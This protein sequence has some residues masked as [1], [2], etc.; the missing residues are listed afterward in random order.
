[1]PYFAFV[2]ASTVVAKRT[3]EGLALF[4][5]L[6]YTKLVWSLSHNTST[7]PRRVLFFHTNSVKRAVVIH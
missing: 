5:L 6:T 1:M 3:G 4:F 2:M 7:Y